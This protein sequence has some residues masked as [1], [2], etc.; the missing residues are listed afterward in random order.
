MQ[1][2]AICTELRSPQE[3]R[4]GD[5]HNIPRRHVVLCAGWSN[6]EHTWIY[7]Y[8]TGGSPDYW[9]P[10]LKRAPLDNMLA[11]GYKPLRYR[12]MARE[13]LSPGQDSKDGLTWAV[14]ATAVAVPNPTVGEP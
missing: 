8:E 11:L 6:P 2:P 4:P 9:K 1:L 7:Y 14:K 3:L 13:A 10:G 5:L 12:G